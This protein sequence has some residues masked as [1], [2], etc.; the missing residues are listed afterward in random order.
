MSFNFLDRWF[1][2]E[3]NV[4]E[5][6]EM[7]SRLYNYMKISEMGKY[8]I[9]VFQKILETYLP[10]LTET[11]IFTLVTS[12]WC[13]GTHFRCLINYRGKMIRN[14]KVLKLYITDEL[15]DAA[16]TGGC[17]AEKI[18]EMLKQRRKDH[19]N[20]SLLACTQQDQ[21]FFVRN[22]KYRF[23][24]HEILIR[25]FLENGWLDAELGQ[26][27]LDRFA[28]CIYDRRMKN[29]SI[30]NDTYE[31]RD[32]NDIEQFCSPSYEGIRGRSTNPSSLTK[33]NNNNSSLPVNLKTLHRWVNVVEILTSH[34]A[35]CS[36]D[37]FALPMLQ[38]SVIQGTHTWNFIT[39]STERKN[40]LLINAC[41]LTMPVELWHCVTSFF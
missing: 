15:L 27:A 11:D 22:C 4:K 34:G 37:R 21:D 19:D 24:N 30:D 31:M 26:I 29:L 39:S 1:A 32:E 2:Y 8:G 35:K 16:I 20:L 38:R 13:N 23:W 7:L 14:K 41:N 18:K 9:T 17:N 28:N 40:D 12:Y 5:T 33:H 6:N 25:A 36:S 3:Q 10:L